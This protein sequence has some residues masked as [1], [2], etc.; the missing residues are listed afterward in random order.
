MEQN[1]PITKEQRHEVYKKILKFYEN[2][3][4]MWWERDKIS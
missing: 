4:F 2:G 3:D 1:T